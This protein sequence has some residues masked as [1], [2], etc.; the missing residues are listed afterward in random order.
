MS[1]GIPSQSL[2]PSAGAVFAPGSFGQSQGQI[3]ALAS[4]VQPQ[5][6]SV[7]FQNFPPPNQGT[8]QIQALAPQFQNA[9]VPY[10]GQRGDPQLQPQSQSQP[11][12]PQQ[13]QYYI[14]HPQLTRGESDAAEKPSLL[15]ME[16]SYVVKHLPP[17]V[18]AQQN[19]AASAAAAAAAGAIPA[20]VS[21]Y[22]MLNQ[23]L[24][25]QQQKSLPQINPQTGMPYHAQQ[26]QQRAKY[27]W[28]PGLSEDTKRRLEQ[29]LTGGFVQGAYERELQKRQRL[30]MKR[31]ALRKRSWSA[32]D[33]YYDGGPPPAGP[34]DEFG[35]PQIPQIRK[36]K[37]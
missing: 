36:F 35:W 1:A 33:D 6:Q 15:E 16:N 14:F 28:P 5:P 18:I 22:P 12:I 37:S 27:Q 31:E 26:Y 25:M 34:V 11:Q 32:D 21:A 4:G 29:Y 30:A 24:Q 19:L 7:A 17:A 13:Q 3:S 8:M 20:S 9:Y 2:Q 23:V 10:L